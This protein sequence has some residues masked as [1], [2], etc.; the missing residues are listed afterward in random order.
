MNVGVMMVVPRLLDRNQTR[1]R[2][3]VRVVGTKA[4]PEVGVTIIFKF[5]LAD[6]SGTIF[7]WHASRYKILQPFYI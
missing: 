2:S 3:V 6:F 4:M 1:M 7:L 5:S